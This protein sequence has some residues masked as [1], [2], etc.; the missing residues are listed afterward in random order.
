MLE[1]NLPRKLVLVLLVMM[2]V[3]AIEFL[4]AVA[5]LPGRLLQRSRPA[6][7]R[8]LPELL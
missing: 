1:S 6:T 8:G 3:L 7:Y 2:V 4:I 5:T